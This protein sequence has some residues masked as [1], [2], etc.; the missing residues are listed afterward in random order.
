MWDETTNKTY[1]DFPV[2]TRV[3]I[4]CSGRDFIFFSPGR[5]TGTV[6]KNT[7]DYLGIV[8]HL[9]HPRVEDYGDPELYVRTKHNFHPTDLLPIEDEDT[10]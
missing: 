8:V 10:P 2:G 7:G 6:I 9:A 4:M 3:R 5:E 1:A